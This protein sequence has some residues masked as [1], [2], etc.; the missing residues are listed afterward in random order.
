VATLR[1][2]A[3]DAG[4]H[5]I[6]WDGRDRLGRRVGAGWYLVAL[7]AGRE[8]RAGRVLLLR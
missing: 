2:G 5:E 3:Q 7:S 4:D 8:R 6:A 1:A